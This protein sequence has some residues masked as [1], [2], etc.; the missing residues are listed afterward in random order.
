[1]KISGPGAPGAPVPPGEGK[2]VEETAAPGEKG[3]AEKLGKAGAPDAAAAAESQQAGALGAVADIIADLRAGKVTAQAAVE[4]VIDRVLA[5]QMGPNAPPAV[6]EQVSAAL[7][8]ALEDDPLVA[9]KLRALG[10]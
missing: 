3:F 9:A 7:R 8:Q 1:M 6:R 2:G 10:E 5:Q 4:R